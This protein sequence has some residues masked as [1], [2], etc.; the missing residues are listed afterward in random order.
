MSLYRDKYSQQLLSKFA[1]KNTYVWN[2]INGFTSDRKHHLDN[3][4]KKTSSEINKAFEQL[5][6]SQDP[7]IDGGQLNAT[8]TA[9]MSKNP[10]VRL[11]PKNTI[12]SKVRHLFKG[13]RANQYLNNL[14]VATIEPDNSIDLKVTLDG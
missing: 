10:D 14:G 8:L 11:F 13:K 6:E 2:V 9:W 4:V 1:E 5:L 12:S 7:S 3:L